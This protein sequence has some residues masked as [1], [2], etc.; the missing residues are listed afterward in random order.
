MKRQ[1]I[2]LFLLVLTVSAAEPDWFSQATKE[3]HYLRETTPPAAGNYNGAGMQL[4]LDRTL[5]SGKP[6]KMEWGPL[7]GCVIED[8][9]LQ[10]GENA[11]LSLVNCTLR[12]VAL[13]ASLRGIISL[14]DCV[15]EDCYIATERS[16]A[17]RE[18]G[19]A[20]TRADAYATT[21]PPMINLSNCVV[22][23]SMLESPYMTGLIARNSTFLLCNAEAG[24]NDGKLDTSRFLDCVFKNCKFFSVD[25]L[26]ATRQCRFDACECLDVLSASAGGYLE[27][28]VL[29]RLAWENGH[30][31]LPAA[32]TN[33]KVQFQPIATQSAAGSTVEHGWDGSLLT[34][35]TPSAAANAAQQAI[36]TSWKV[37]P[38]A[39]TMA[40]VPTTNDPVRNP[41]TMAETPAAAAF[42][43]QLTQVNGLLIVQ[44]SSGKTAG[45]SSRM[46]L[47]ALPSSG[48]SPSTVRFNQS[49]G[50]DM[51][52]AL[53]EVSR[54]SQL[55]HKGWPAGHAIEIGFDD[56]YVPKDGPSAA[57]ACA[58]LIE[59]A[60]TGKEWDPAFAV[61]GDM[62]ADGSVQPIGGVQAKIRGATQ[63]ACKIAGVPYKN[64]KDVADLLV[65]EGPKPL[66]GITIFGL[67]TFEDAL[68]LAS[69]ERP[70]ALQAA[71]TDFDN[72]RKVMLRDP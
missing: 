44:L 55:R 42:K 63:G 72:M 12:R 13:K 56:K 66:V 7:T 39:K 61:T 41:A 70:Q 15:L 36:A 38:Y 23:R 32:T 29:V 37:E 24:E 48:Q 51:Q 1:G 4:V 34:L 28:P 33:S 65:L 49:V 3:R 22:A 47:S 11:T 18:D 69:V 6:E 67:R 17:R 8:V 45:Q 30:P 59:A 21:G 58:L 10:A 64:E 43:S 5:A 53:N 40:Q 54:F 50:Q 26:L 14:Q 2:T 52:K 27:Q 16:V 31:A 57:V 60:L 68:L 71:L 20:Q 46:S 62:N 35:V 9:V 19:V 25:F